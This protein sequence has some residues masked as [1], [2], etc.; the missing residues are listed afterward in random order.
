MSKKTLRSYYSLVRAKQADETR[1]RIAASARELI[2]SRGFEA[3]TMEAIARDAGVAVPTVYSVFGSKCRILSELVERAAF[4][5][6]FQKLIAEAERLSDPTAR[7]RLTARIARGIY[8]AERSESEL[9][10]QAR[11]VIPEMALHE[12]ERECGRYEAHGVTVTYIVQSG[13]LHPGIT[14]EEAR[15]VLWTFTARDLYRMLVLERKWNAD[16]YEQWIGDT[17]ISSLIATPS[18]LRPDLR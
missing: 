5:P 13:Q 18:S 17:L 7:L 16:R 10:R 15:D 1:A 4:G 2:L 6:T 3:A 14:A 11:A 9:L 12:H 8:D